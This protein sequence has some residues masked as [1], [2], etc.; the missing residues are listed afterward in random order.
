[1]DFR[2]ARSLAAL[3]ALAVFVLLGVFSAHAAAPGATCPTR[4][5]GGGMVIHGNRQTAP[6]A[7][8]HDVGCG[9][10]GVLTSNVAPIVA[11]FSAVG[12]ALTAL[13]TWRRR[14]AGIP[15]PMSVLLTS[16][17]FRPPR[18]AFDI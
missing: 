5:D 2:P 6:T 15:Q 9:G 1:V 11:V 12:I 3:C 10:G 13:A 8:V 16:D 7:C 14:S 4:C 18:P 17:L